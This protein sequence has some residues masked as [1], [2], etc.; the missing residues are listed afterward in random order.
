MSLIF[1]DLGNKEIFNVV[2]HPGNQAERSYQRGAPD[3]MLTKSLEDPSF[4]KLRIKQ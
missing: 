2:L 1:V 3:N 4:I